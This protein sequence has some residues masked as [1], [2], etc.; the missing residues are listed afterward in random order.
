VEERLGYLAGLLENTEDAV[1]AMDERYFLTAWNKGAETLYGWRAEEVV[2]RHA[3]DVARTNLS[4]EERAELRREL[5]ANGRWRGELTVARKD[6]TTVE[7]ELISVALWGEHR[8]TTGYLTI[9]RDISERKRAEEK[10]RDAHRRTENILNSISATFFTVDRNWRIYLRQRPSGD[11]L[12][13]SDAAR[14]DGCG[15]RRQEC[16]GRSP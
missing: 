8:D 10:L 11:G 6:G 15:A 16:M 3:G 1:V 14:R 9:H 7:A 4:E 2:G 5:A 13:K 12:S